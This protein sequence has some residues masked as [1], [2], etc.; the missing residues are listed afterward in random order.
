M[1][2]MEGLAARARM[3]GWLLIGGAAFMAAGDVWRAANQETAQARVIAVKETCWLTAIGAD[4]RP[5]RDRM[6]CAEA[7]RAKATRTSEAVK[8][9]RNTS[10]ATLEFR[11]ARGQTVR[12]EPSTAAFGLARARVGDVVTLAYDPA[13]PRSVRG[14]A[15]L[16]NLS[17]AKWAGIAGIVL[18]WLG[19]VLRKAGVATRGG[20]AE[21]AEALRKSAEQVAAQRPS[22]NGGFAAIDR[23]ATRAGTGGKPAPALPAKPSAV[24]AAAR[25]T[26]V[27]RGRTPSRTPAKPLPKGTP[28]VVSP[29]RG[30]LLGLFR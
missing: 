5:R 30:G 9:G 4:G 19:G 8:I 29:R 7:E 26:T 16:E 2:V 24:E 22:G 10:E 13:N 17:T 1:S 15:R 14:P 23:L 3:F 6:T 18:I 28:R 21:L 20:L 25:R 12:I 27:T 11:T